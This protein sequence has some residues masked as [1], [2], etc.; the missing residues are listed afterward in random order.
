MR[1]CAATAA[2]VAIALL[3]LA[4]G[5]PWR[6]PPLWPGARYTAGDRDRAIQHGL[7]FI[8]D[9]VA[10]NR[11]SFRDFG[12]DLLN[13][14]YNIAATSEDRE[15]RRM[16]W[17]MGHERALEWRRLNPELPAA[18]GPNGI[19]SLVF[20]SD[21]AERLGV[22]GPRLRTQLREAAAR[23]SAYDYLWFDPV[24]EPPPSDVPEACESCGRQNQRGATACARC[25][26]KLAM[27]SRY[28]VFLDALITAYSGD[29]YG[30][31]LGAHYVDVLKWLPAMRP[32][33]ARTPDHE[34]EYYSGVYAVTHVIYTY[35][36]YSHARVAPECF[37]EE[38]EHLKRNLPEAIAGKDPETMGEYLDSLR[39]FGLTF[40]DPLIRTGIE[41]LLSAQ[42]RDGSWGD[43]NDPD[44][45]DRYHSTWT[46]IDG[47]R[48]YRWTRVLP[49]PAL[50]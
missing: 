23:F 21:A 28:D 50:P 9:S 41:Y 27:Q 13:A 32:Y 20:G 18:A 5:N 11:G 4:A 40:R 16:A 7:N 3:A 12:H 10:R 37:P 43:P 25:G 2:L 33:P 15:L 31:T 8:Y 42:N 6:G 36:D 38:F 19:S 49:C 34:D 30:V 14:F 47:L 29:L 46:A 39:A 17:S 35:N 44:P 45:Y 48:D 22:P 24:R 26:A 1:A